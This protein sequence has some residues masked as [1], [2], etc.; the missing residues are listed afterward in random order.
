MSCTLSASVRDLRRK[1]YA[2]IV[3]YVAKAILTPFGH[4]AH[5]DTPFARV[6]WT[7]RQDFKDRHREEDSRRRASSGRRAVHHVPSPG[8]RGALHSRCGR[9]AVAW[10]KRGSHASQSWND[11]VLHVV[12]A[13]RYLFGPQLYESSR[14]GRREGLLHQ[15]RSHYP[16]CVSLRFPTLTNMVVANTL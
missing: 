14:V 9:R 1:R 5:P 2:S 11:E 8:R 10:L 6:L 15:G 13:R 3:L 16:V 7:I 12:L 4:A